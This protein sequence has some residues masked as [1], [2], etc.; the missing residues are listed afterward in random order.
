[1]TSATH[2]TI[3]AASS[4]AS[5]SSKEARAHMGSKAA[6]EAPYA[7]SERRTKTAALAAAT[8]VRAVDVRAGWVFVMSGR[9]NG[10]SPDGFHDAARPCAS[11]TIGPWSQRA[12]RRGHVVLHWDQG[13]IVG[14]GGVRITWVTP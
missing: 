10:A 4:R 9:L 1:M 7:P 11:R 13:P 8:R 3:S 6:I 14:P 5:P 12:S 2:A